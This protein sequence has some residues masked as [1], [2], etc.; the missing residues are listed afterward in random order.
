MP[1]RQ[2]GALYS[3]TPQLSGILAIKVNGQGIKPPNERGYAII[4]RK[5][6][7]G[8]LIE[9]EMPLQPVRVRCDPRVVA[10]Q[11]RVAL[12]YGPLIYNIESVDLPAGVFSDEVEL[13]AGAAL[14]AEWN[15]DLLGGVM[16][17]RGTFAD[18]TPLRAIP[19]YARM[20]RLPATRG[21]REKRKV[22]SV[23]WIKES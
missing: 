17:I 18:G 2:I 10:N 20:N 14:D 13:S 22:R 19:H 6:S 5:W 23:V 3:A 8:D 15:A 9:I 1:A 4:D 21:E 16:T 11:R 7:E 12:Q